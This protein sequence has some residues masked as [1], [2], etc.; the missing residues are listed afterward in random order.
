ML[1]KTPLS[2]KFKWPSSS[3]KTTDNPPPQHLNPL[4][5]SSMEPE[6]LPNVCTAGTFYDSVNTKKSKK[7]VILKYSRRLALKLR[8]GMAN[9]QKT[10]PALVTTC[11]TFRE[12]VTSWAPGLRCWQFLWKLFQTLWWHLFSRGPCGEHEVLGLQQDTLEPECVANSSKVILLMIMM[13]SCHKNIL[14]S[15]V[16]TSTRSGDPQWLWMVIRSDF[17]DAGWWPRHWH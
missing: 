13:M 2:E 3:L 12:A 11:Q 16:D 4:F 10:L 1:T 9:N 8:W 7:N 6:C 15:L 5:R 17:A 14:W